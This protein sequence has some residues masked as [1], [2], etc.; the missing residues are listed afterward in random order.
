V[1]DISWRS[2]TLRTPANHLILVPNSKF[3]DSILTNYSLP[4]PLSNVVMAVNVA[5]DSD[6]RRV[7]AVLLD[8]AKRMTAELPQLV[9][10][11]EPVVRLQAFLD[12]SLQ[13]NV[14]LR[15]HDYDSQFDIWGEVHQRV[16]DRLRREGITI[17]F[18]TRDVFL[19]EA[20]SDGAPPKL[21][22]TVA[23]R[24]EAVSSP[25]TAPTQ[26]VASPSKRNS[27]A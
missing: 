9:H 2:T 8:E 4:E 26:S 19:H 1:T 22:E 15:V 25:E 23:S 16:Y 14:V 13:F 20:K 17:P 3:A 11:S 6:A 10:D 12:S 24:P 7:H 18:P 27:P 21:P 5:Y